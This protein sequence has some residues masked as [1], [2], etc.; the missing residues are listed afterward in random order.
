MATPRLLGLGELLW[1]LLPD[2][3]QL[4][5]APANFAYHACALGGRGAVAS[6]VGDDPL[7]REA[8]ERLDGLGVDRSA[9]AVDPERPTGTV[10]VALDAAGQP[11]YTIHEGV[12]WDAIP[13]SGALLDRAAAADAICFGSLAQRSAASR[14]TLR[15]ALDAAQP[16]CLRVFDINLRQ[17]YY[18]RDVILASL[19]Q[20]DAFK[21]NDEELPVVA[22]LLDLPAQTRPAME[23]LRAR[24]DLRWVALTRGAAGSLL[25]ADGAW[26]EHPGEPVATV[27][28]TVGAGDAFTAALALGTLLG[29]A[30]EVR[31][32]HANRVAAFVC[33]A[34]GATPALPEALRL[35]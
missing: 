14:A 21:V 19:E 23:A 3:R 2:G 5:G 26:A 13:A 29:Q 28:D 24:F 11:S 32:A 30:P 20:A 16:A 9:V 18:D 35:A 15:R 33:A 1:D 25:L 6:C 8:L 4:G 7:G 34:A 10:S 17:A 12:A 31:N 22:R 27:A